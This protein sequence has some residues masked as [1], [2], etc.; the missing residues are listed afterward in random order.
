MAPSDPQSISI[1]AMR[2][3][4]IYEHPLTDTALDEA[5]A[6]IENNR[7]TRDHVRMYKTDTDVIVKAHAV[8]EHWR[9][10]WTGKWLSRHLEQ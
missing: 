9:D 7:L 2:Q 1:A 6:Y 4:V 5:K 3:V 8:P 10:T